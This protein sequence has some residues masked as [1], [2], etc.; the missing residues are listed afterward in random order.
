MK[1]LSF[2]ML[3]VSTAVLAQNAGSSPAEQGRF[4]KQILHNDRLTAYLVEIPSQQSTPT[5]RHVKDTLSILVSGGTTESV[6]GNGSPLHIKSKAG[7]AV[8]RSAPYSHSVKNIGNEPFRV[9]DIEFA[10]P[11]G[12]RQKPAHKSF[13]SCNPASK[14]ACVTEQYLF[15]TQRFCVED[16]EMGPGAKSS[17]HT[18]DTDHMMV[19]ITDY[20]IDDETTGKG[21]IHRAVKSGGVEYLPAGITHVL[22]NTTGKTV[23]FVAVIFQ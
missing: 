15:C 13:H 12:A 6:M 10:D 23:R 21:V 5:H 8:F 16:V 1:L 7:D 9:A 22:T 14:V 11:Q 4:R 2:A 20:K 18:H 19:A 17:K 3:F